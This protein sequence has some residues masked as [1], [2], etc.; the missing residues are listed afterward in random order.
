MTST[1]LPWL[2]A[3]AIAA[4]RPDRSVTAP[5][6][7]GPGSGAGADALAVCTDD[8][9]RDRAVAMVAAQPR[10]LRRRATGVLDMW[11]EELTKTPSMR[12]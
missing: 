12:K 6:A 3:A 4:F 10:S 7:D 1:R 8:I 5:A 2:R 11:G 9:A